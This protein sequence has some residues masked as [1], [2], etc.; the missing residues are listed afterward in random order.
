M[1]T[2]CNKEEESGAGESLSSQCTQGIDEKRLKREREG[3]VFGG[4][5]EAGGSFAIGEASC[6]QCRV[7]LYRFTTERRTS[8]K[9][10]L[11]TVDFPWPPHSLPSTQCQPQP[12]FSLYLTSPQ[13]QP[14]LC[15]SRRKIGKL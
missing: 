14:P 10:Y 4:W 9:R 11:L 5:N 1:H 2:V 7:R 8:V 6:D 3:A 12:P 13:S 15:L